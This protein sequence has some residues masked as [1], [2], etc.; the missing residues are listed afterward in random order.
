MDCANGR[1]TLYT[2]SE[3]MCLKRDRVL[4]GTVDGQLTETLYGGYRGV[5]FA[6]LFCQTELGASAVALRER[7]GVYCL[8]PSEVQVDLVDHS[9]KGKHV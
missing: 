3:R 1:G 8:R 6:V 7:S 9:L 4:V 2:L 5:P